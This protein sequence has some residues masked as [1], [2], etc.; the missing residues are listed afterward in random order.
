M[1]K[2][3][4]NEISDLLHLQVAMQKCITDNCKTE[5]NKMKKITENFH[6]KMKKILKDLQQNKIT[7]EQWTQKVSDL[8]IEMY[9]TTQRFNLVKCQVDECKK[10]TKAAA[11]AAINVFLKNYKRGHP[12]HK[13]VKKYKKIFEKRITAEDVQAFDIEFQKLKHHL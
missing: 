9:E 1:S 5:Y 7:S 4:K 8:T 11:L 2:K 3:S 10:E 6:K 12:I 13:L